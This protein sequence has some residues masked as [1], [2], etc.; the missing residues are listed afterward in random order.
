LIDDDEDQI[1]AL[2]ER[3]LRETGYEIV[4]VG[5]GAADLEAVLTA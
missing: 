4:A 3:A 5:D 1:R 2:L